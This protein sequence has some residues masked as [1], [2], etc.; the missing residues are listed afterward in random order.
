M[1]VCLVGMISIIAKQY[2]NSAFI[3]LHSAFY[4]EV[5]PMSNEKWNENEI[6]Q[7]EEWTGLTCSDIIFDSEVD[8]T[9]ALKYWMKK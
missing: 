3:I 5:F 2:L 9:K 4:F 7:L 6:K 1:I 8:D